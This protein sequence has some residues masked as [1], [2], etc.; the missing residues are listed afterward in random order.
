MNKR[1]RVITVFLT[2]VLAVVACTPS[3]SHPGTSTTLLPESLYFLGRDN[4]SVSQVFRLERDGRT[5]T[6]LTFEP[7]NVTEYDVSL[8]D[9][10]IAYVASNQF[11][12]ANTDGTNRRVLID[13]GTGPELSGSYHP[14]FSPDGKTLAYDQNGL[15]LYDMSN[16][17][18]RLVLQNRFGDTSPDGFQF[19]LELYWPERYSPDGTKLLLALGHW[20]MAPSHAI[21]YPDTNTLLRYAEPQEYIYCCSFHGGPIWAPDSSSFYGVASVHDTAY[22]SGELWRVDATNGAVTRMLKTENGMLNLPKEIFYAP[23]GR[24]YFFLGTY[25]VDSGYFD[26]PVLELVRAAPDGVTD[27]AVLRSENFT[28]MNE[29]LWAPDASF[30]IVASAPDLNRDQG[31]GVLELYPTDGQKSMVWLAPFGRQMKWGP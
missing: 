1:F 4:Q 27:R 3:S 8:A 6:Q 20:E 28:R 24:L 9:G 11:L 29:A 5:K 31:G 10:K 14:V 13:G 7:F 2:F 19:P 23:D 26:A 15:N 30:V 22:Q 21:Y 12:L 16:S 25:S 17:V 18:S